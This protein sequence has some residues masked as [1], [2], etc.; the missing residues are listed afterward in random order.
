MSRRGRTVNHQYIG[1]AIGLAVLVVS[2]CSAAQ[3]AAAVVTVG[4]C[5]AEP[6]AF[7]NCALEKA[8][9]FNPPRSSTGK[10]NLEGYYRARLAQAFSVE[11][12][13]GSEPLVGD[14]VM[15]WE[16]APPM[17]V[18]P[19]DRKIPYQAWAAPIGRIGENYHRY[20]D[21]RTAC[22]PGGVPRLALQDPN[23]ILQPLTDDY[24][25]WLFEDHHVHRVI[26]MNGSPPL[27]D[28]IKMT[29]GDARGR[30]EGNTLVI[31][32]TNLNGYTWFDDSGNFYTNF[33]H[34]IERL[35]L[36]DPDTIH[37]E[38][39]VE[40]PKAYTRTWKLVWALVRQKDPGFELMEEACREGEHD[41]SRIRQS[42]GYKFYF[43]DSWRGR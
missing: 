26:A 1:F 37:Y 19:P 12:V 8:K 41:V 30:W 4:G 13:S 35:T 23:Q 43:G 5:P 31:D 11:G 2:P 24:I 22:G 14:P 28:A 36:I 39:T 27:G 25:L 42:S 18:D 29:N 15:P 38:V 9:T 33:A 34:L 21:P 16:L 32:V 3:Q 6:L 17:I 40:D 7:H 20:L 10:P